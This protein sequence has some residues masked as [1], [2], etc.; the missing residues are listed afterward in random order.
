MLKRFLLSAVCIPAAFAALSAQKV[1]TETV[2]VNANLYDDTKLLYRNEMS[3]GLIAH[4]N[5]FGANFRRGQH[6]TGTRK[7]VFEVEFATYKHPKEVKT[8]NPAFDNAK[9][10]YYGKLNSVFL[11]RPGVGY[12]NVIFSKP[13]RSGVEIRYVTFLG[14][15]LCFEKPVYLQ[16]LKR[17]PIDNYY[18]LA[19]E[20][21]DP[22]VHYPDNIYGR[23]PYFK[24][25]D[26]MKIVPGGYAKFGLTF[27]YGALDDAVKAI[28]TGVC[29]DVY[30]KVIPIMATQR[31]QQ[32]FVTLYLHVLY[33][34][35]WF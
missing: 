12:Q 21:Y 35:K 10:F 30:P 22:A 27:E 9:G 25:F 2:K 18:D 14:G 31:N 16:I 6:V 8:V 5:G 3:G 13:E 4:S 7:R 23:A 19:T 1:E 28:E 15:S 26:E 11:L 33:G 20:K 17:T 34:R 32:V 24:G 29:V